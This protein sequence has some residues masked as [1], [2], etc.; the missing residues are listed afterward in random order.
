MSSIQPLKPLIST[1]IAFFWLAC[2]VFIDTG[3]SGFL[4]S[5]FNNPQPVAEAWKW[6]TCLIVGLIWLLVQIFMEAPGAASRLSLVL[7][8]TVLWLGLLMFYRFDDPGYGGTVAFFALVGGLVVVIAWMR[9]L[10]DEI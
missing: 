5:F 7:S 4:Q 8:G 9:Y 6:G 3:P 10:A 1:L 2:F